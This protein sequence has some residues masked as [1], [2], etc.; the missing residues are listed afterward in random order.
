[1]LRLLLSFLAITGCQPHSPS[2][3]TRAKSNGINPCD[4]SVQS[5]STRFLLQEID[6]AFRSCVQVTCVKSKK[7]Y[8]NFFQTS[9]C[10]I[11]SIDAE[12]SGSLVS[13]M[14]QQKLTQGFIT[15]FSKQIGATSSIQI[16]KYQSTAH[17]TMA[18]SIMD[19]IVDECQGRENNSESCVGIDLFRATQKGNFI[20]RFNMYVEDPLLRSTTRQIR[21]CLYS[22]L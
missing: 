14:R 19:S 5:D 15:G 18:K 3:V 7:Q 22:K 1:M 11:E 9:S 21:S 8:K 12:P 2:T 17:A 20:I 4:Y 10:S 6:H 13:K 16:L